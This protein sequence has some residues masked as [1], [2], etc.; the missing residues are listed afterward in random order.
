MTS[1]HS[2]KQSIIE[3]K[4]YKGPTTTNDLFLHCFF[5]RPFLLIFFLG[6]IWGAN[7]GQYVNHSL[8][9]QIFIV[10]LLSDNGP[11]VWDTGLN[12][13]D[14]KDMKT[15][16]HLLEQPK[17]G[18]LTTPNADTYAEQ[19]KLSLLVKMQN[20]TA[21]LEDSLGVSYKTKHNLT[22][23]SRNCAPWYLP[24]EIE[25]LCPH[26]NL[27]MVVHSSFINNCPK[28]EATKMSFSRWMDKKTVVHPDNGILFII[29]SKWVI[30]LWKRY[31]GILNGYCSVKETNLESLYTVWSQL[32]DILGKIK[33][34][35]QQKH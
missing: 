2:N 8:I 12:K 4:V 24:K 6:G 13:T 14:K 32:Y 1:L 34:W 17:S 33:L 5:S 3:G 26:K 22:I 35:K 15:T 30:K 25:N 19:Q 7:E 20:G 16:T 9:Q 23:W 10:Q 29:K 11:G 18:T 28:L 21:T 27:H 31:R